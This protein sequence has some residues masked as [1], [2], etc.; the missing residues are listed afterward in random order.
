M[1][2]GFSSIQAPARCGGYG[3]NGVACQQLL[4]AIRIREA[5][6]TTPDRGEQH[7]GTKRG[8]G[9]QAGFRC[10]NARALAGSAE[11]RANLERV[12]ERMARAT[13]R[14]GRRPQDVK[15]IA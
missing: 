4:L 3:V 10:Y 9:R 14:S 2:L 13:E 5:I 7:H 12:R 8:L 6:V 1:S 11:I 15:L